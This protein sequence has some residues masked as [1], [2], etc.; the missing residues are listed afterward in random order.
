MPLKYVR[1]T[2]GRE[3]TIDYRNVRNG[4][5]NCNIYSGHR[6]PRTSTQKAVEGQL[7]VENLYM[8]DLECAI[9]YISKKICRG[10]ELVSEDQTKLEAFA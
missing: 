5:I 4:G 3:F 2:T 7:L 8:K 6:Q 10:E 9:D 1:K